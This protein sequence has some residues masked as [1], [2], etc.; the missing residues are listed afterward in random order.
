MSTR[1][2]TATTPAITEDNKSAPSQENIGGTNDSVKRTLSCPITIIEHM[3]GIRIVDG[4]NGKLEHTTFLHALETNNAWGGLFHASN[5]CGQEFGTRSMNSG[6][7]ITAIVHCHIGLVIKRGIDM[8]II[9][10]LIFTLDGKG[11]NAILADQSCRHI[12]LCGER[13]RGTQH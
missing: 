9:G 10:L 13:I 3:F 7:K 6:H 11:G 5:N 12:I 2:N 8:A 4:Q 1:G